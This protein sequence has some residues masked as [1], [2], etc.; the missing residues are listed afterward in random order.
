MIAVVHVH[1]KE[2]KIDVGFGTGVIVFVLDHVI[3]WA[4]RLRS[5]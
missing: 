3:L 2:I 4:G 5:P 1:K